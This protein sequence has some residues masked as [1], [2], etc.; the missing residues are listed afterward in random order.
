M[1]LSS[2][3]AAVLAL[4]SV[5][6]GNVET[7]SHQ[8]D[9]R[10]EC[11]EEP[12]LSTRQLNLMFLGVL[13]L[14]PGREVHLAVHGGCEQG[15]GE[16]VDGPSALLFRIGE[17]I[18]YWIDQGD[19]R[20]EWHVL[21][22]ANVFLKMNEEWEPAR[23]GRASVQ[24]AFQQWVLGGEDPW[25]PGVIRR[26][27]LGLVVEH[28]ERVPID[29]VKVLIRYYDEVL[30]SPEELHVILG[31]NLKASCR[32]MSSSLAPKYGACRRE[33]WITPP[34]EGSLRI[35][36]TRRSGR[37]GLEVWKDGMRIASE[38]ATLLDPT[39]PFHW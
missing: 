8:A 10:F 33:D 3:F 11:L 25:G 23:S 38:G 39:R 4:N 36:F 32:H 19:G 22:G 20:A 7:E 34:P 27:E 31:N 35:H 5:Q 18:F 37:R 15:K 6:T 1:K 17:N 9:L 16:R 12:E 24:F 26:R 30:R 29:E 14:N 13:S 28:L 2:V 21:Q